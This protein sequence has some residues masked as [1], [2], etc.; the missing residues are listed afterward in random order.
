MYIVHVLA[1]VLYTRA[2]HCQ[3]PNNFSDTETRCPV[4][5]GDS[6]IG[7][8]GDVGDAGGD[9]EKRLLVKPFSTTAV[10][11]GSANRNATFV[12]MTHD[13]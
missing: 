5:A 1:H 8:A 13:T 2:S 9:D 10:L 6:V 7:D 12:A 3:D 11:N 4:Y